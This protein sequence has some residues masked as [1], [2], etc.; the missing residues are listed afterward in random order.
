MVDLVFE[1]LAIVLIL[2]LS[3][4][5]YVLLLARVL[6]K[7][8]LVPRQGNIRGDRGIRKCV[9]NGGRSVTYEPKLDIRKYMSQYVL[10]SENGEKFIKCKINEKIKSLKYE[11]IVY[12]RKNQP[13]TTL[14]IAEGISEKGYTSKVM[15][16][17][18]ASFVHVDIKSVNDT[19]LD[20]E[21][22]DIYYG[23]G[24]LL[25]FSVTLVLTLA[26][27]LFSN[28]VAMK[29]MELV[30]AFSKH[31][32]HTDEIIPLLVIAAVSIAFSFFITLINVNRPC[33]FVWNKNGI[34]HKL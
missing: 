4:V 27:G 21:K 12:D 32:Q 13:V 14:E 7:I 1:H 20:A 16:P 34:A 5:L 31:V 10:F 8:L 24:I 28:Y 23:Y 25:F 19:P 9:F 6:P 17:P 11:L 33:Y 29:L 15:L 30:F 22:H 26:E 18:E 3:A 2:L